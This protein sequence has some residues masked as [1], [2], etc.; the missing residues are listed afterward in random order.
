MKYYTGFEGS[1]TAKWAAASVK[2]ILVN[3]VYIGTM[4][5]GKQEKVNYKVKKRI[6]KPQEEWICVKI[7][8]R[9]LYQKLNF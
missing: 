9:P 8:I 1:S 6:D 2:R 3:P 5:Q 7:P 4:V